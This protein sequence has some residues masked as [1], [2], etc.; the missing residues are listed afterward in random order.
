MTTLEQNPFRALKDEMDNLVVGHEAVKM[1]LLLGVISREHIYI[2]GPPGTAK[3]MLAEIISKAAQLN[4][5]F[6]QLHRDTRL[7]ELVGD[8]VISKE[9]VGSGEVIRQSIVKGGILTAEICLLDDISRAPGESLNV[10][11]RILNERKFGEER[12]PLLTA[13]ATSNPTADE[14]YNE[15]LDPANLDRFVL[16]IN[17][18]GLSYARKWDEAKQIIN[19]YSKRPLDYDVPV[20]VSKKVFDEH[21]EKLSIVEIPSEVQEGL[22]DF[23]TTLI[24]EFGL[25]ETNSLISDRTF[26]VKSLKIIRSHA[27]L[28]GRQQCTVEDLRA[29]K[30]MTAFRIPEEIY[31]QLDEI[32]DS[33]IS[34]KKLKRDSASR[35]EQPQNS[36]SEK[37]MPGQKEKESPLGEKEPSSPL[38]EARKNFFEA[39]KELKENLSKEQDGTAPPQSDNNVPSRSMGRPSDEEGEEEGQEK[40]RASE[41]LPFASKSNKPGSD[42]ETWLGT[43]KRNLGTADNVK[44]IMKALE[45]NIQR[46]MALDAPHP[47]GQPRRWKRMRFFEEIEDVDPAEGMHWAEH[48]TPTLPRVH[49]RE[50]EIM[51]G[52]IAILRDISTSMMGIY[53][54]WS[55]SV[56]RGVVELARAKKMKVGYVEFNHRSYKYKRNGKFFTRDYRWMLELA[57]RTECSGNTNY[58]DALKD[59]ISEFRGR[60]LRNKHILFITDGI[61]TSGDCEVFNE[62]FRAVKLGIC[63]HSI[64]IGSK[65]Y[66]KI[67]QRISEETSGT[68]FIASRGKDG[69]IRIEKRDKKLQSNTPNKYSVDPFTNVFSQ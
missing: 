50:K 40:Q 52:E 5:F 33:V 19:L 66:P 7:S 54:E 57:S 53:S 20:R 4:F 22:L 64:F 26:F 8:L 32:L 59:A 41:K 16:Q 11:L 69:N 17:A 43:G 30:Y 29:L 34:K 21:Y 13:I 51:G 27:L 55:S 1:C 68:Q 45:G 24:E 56:V 39:L 28:H 67:L 2:E 48:T 31:L 62:R 18:R 23:I 36:D 38:D 49:K 12:I 14:Y 9:A 61:P 63:V 58:E 42:E 15:P 3:T 47:G 44:I 25:N 35:I 6:Y 37:H 10:L 46:S 65:N 60:G